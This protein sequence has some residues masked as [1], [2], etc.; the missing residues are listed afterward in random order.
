MLMDLRD[1]ISGWIAYTIVGLITIPFVLWGVG[2]Y[3]QGGQAAP[4]ASVNG[5]EIDQAVFDQAYEQERQRIAQNFGGNVPPDVLAGMDIKRQVLNGLVMREVLSQYAQANGLRVSDA[6]L[7]A[8]LRSI[9]AFQENGVFSQ[10]RYEQVLRLQGQVPLSFEPLV[11]HDL[12]IG[13]LQNG[14][15]QSAFVT[16]ADVDGYVRLRDQTRSVQVYLLPAA[17][18]LAAIKPDGAALQAYF[19]AHRADFRRPERV[20]L[21]MIELDVNRVAAMMQ[22]T[23]D[24]IQQAYVAYVATQKQ[25]EVRQARHILITVPEGTDAEVTRKTIEN[26]QQRLQMGEDFAVLAEQFSQDTGSAKQGGKLGAVT[27]GMMVEP[28]EKALFALPT[29]GSVSD[30]VRSPFGW[31]LIKLDGIEPVTPKPL[32]EVRAQMEQDARMHLA[33]NQFH[34]LADRLATSSYE[35]PDSLAPTAEQLG[36]NVITSTWFDRSKGEGLA[37]NAKVRQAAFSDEVLK[38]GRNSDL[39]DLGNQQAAVVRVIEHEDAADQPFDAVRAQVEQHVIEQTLATQMQA[40][41]EALRVALAQAGEPANVEQLG[42][43]R[44][45][46]GDI[47]RQAREIDADVARAVFALKPPAAGAVE[48]QALRLPSGDFA[49]VRL[50]AVKQGDPALLTAGER[51]SVFGELRQNQATS[52]GAVFEA[53]LRAKAEITQRQDI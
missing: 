26:L 29:V 44:S 6:E 43:K 15:S 45:F 33:E 37:A 36:L 24:D 31:H 3:F 8:L 7:A 50:L 11:R 23:E 30:P 52:D 38:Q 4:L 2:E 46:S 5:H 14:I 32:Q 40:D 13:Q 18:R 53:Y 1:K 10:A 47:K 25:L 41:A 42:A 21:E 51:R 19:D 20:R 22:P 34:D 35:N 9:P 48:T 16:Q 27:R 39:L 28:F 49:V 12:V 17:T